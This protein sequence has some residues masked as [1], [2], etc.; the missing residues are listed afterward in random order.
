MS[1]TAIR[2]VVSAAPAPLPRFQG[3]VR[4]QAALDQDRT[5]RLLV[6]AALTIAAVAGSGLGSL[7]L[8][9]GEPAV[10]AWSVMAGGLIIRCVARRN[11][12]TFAAGWRDLLLMGVLSL[13][14]AAAASFAQP[15]AMLRLAAGIVIV[16]VA[17]LVM[18]QIGAAVVYWRS[19]PVLVGTG[20]LG[21]AYAYWLISGSTGIAAGGAAVAAIM[22][23][24][25]WRPGRKLEPAIGLSRAAGVAWALLAWGGAGGPEPHHALSIVALILFLAVDTWGEQRRSFASVAAV[26]VFLQLATLPPSEQLPLGSLVLQPLCSVAVFVVLAVAGW[27]FMS[28]AR[29]LSPAATYRI[30]PLCVVPRL[31]RGLDHPVKISVA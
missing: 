5:W 10:L 3:A 29:L 26:A 28:A 14:V 4:F 17:L 25:T 13:T 2:S 21:G 30:A 11:G 19:S 24:T 1:D 12:L 7:A 15:A 20:A 22:T 31:D 9:V 23:L 27:R 6:I 8:R 18:N 16:T